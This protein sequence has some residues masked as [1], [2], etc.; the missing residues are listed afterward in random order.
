M[1]DITLPA[2]AN[3]C[4]EPVSTKVVADVADSKGVDPTELPPLYYAIDSDA[5]DQLFE[6]Q[7]GN[8]SVQVQFTF[9]GCDVTVS[10]DGRVTVTPTDPDTG[11]TPSA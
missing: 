5:L 9:A 2:S 10:S 3:H 11:S 4:T 7:P 8:G 1:T 6:P